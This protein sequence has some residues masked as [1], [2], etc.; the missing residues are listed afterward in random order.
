MRVCLIAKLVVTTCLIAVKSLISRVL[1]Q[2]EKDRFAGRSSSHA[3]R[4]ALKDQLTFLLATTTRAAFVVTDYDNMMYGMSF[5]RKEQA[6][7]LPSWQPL[8]LP[9]AETAFCWSREASTTIFHTRTT[10]EQQKNNNQDSDC[11]I[12]HMRN[13]EQK[14]CKTYSSRDSHVVTHRSTNLPFNCLCMAERTGCPV[15]S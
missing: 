5:T 1:R 8:R 3:R 9:K 7:D 10:N 15:F 12:S 11:R 4:L 6:V 13:I 14:R 2:L